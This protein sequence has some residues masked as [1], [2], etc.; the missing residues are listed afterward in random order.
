MGLGTISLAEIRLLHTVLELLDLLL[1]LFFILDGT[2]FPGNF[3][4]HGKYGLRS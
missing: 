1:G 2:I 4:C 3:S